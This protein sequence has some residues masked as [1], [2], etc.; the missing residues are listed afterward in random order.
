M[1]TGSATVVLLYD[2][3]LDSRVWDE[4]FETFARYHTVIRYDRRGYGK[5]EPPSRTFSDAEDLHHLLQ[6]FRARSAHLVGMS[7]GG[8]VALDFTLEYPNIGFD[9][10]ARTNQS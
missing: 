6:S 2:G 3:L 8:R 4:Q 7:N 1:G 10:L 9:P 5:S